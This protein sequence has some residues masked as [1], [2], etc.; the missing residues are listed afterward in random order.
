[1]TDETRLSRAAEFLYKNARLLERRRFEFHF[2]QGGR[3]AVL[4]SLEAYRHPDGG[5]GNGLEP[6]K[7]VPDSQPIDQEFA[8]HILHQIGAGPEAV[9][10]V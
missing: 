10:G 2:R 8:L 6:D 1:M 9:G 4:R 7:R 5:F 3:E